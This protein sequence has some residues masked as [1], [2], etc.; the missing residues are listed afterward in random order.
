MKA[1]VLHD[2]GDIRLADVSEPTRQAPTDAIMRLTA[3]AIGVTDLRVLRGTV[4]GMAKGS[5]AK[6]S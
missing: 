1:V 5:V 2:P 6:R 4:G 3:S